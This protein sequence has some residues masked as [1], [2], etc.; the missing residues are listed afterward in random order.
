LF[1]FLEVPFFSIFP[2]LAYPM[3][4]AFASTFLCS[5]E[6]HGLASLV[7]AHLSRGERRTKIRV[8]QSSTRTERPQA[9]VI[10]A[11]T[12]GETEAQWKDKTRSI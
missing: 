9:E 5:Q 4:V 6:I 12:D 3:T 7:D 11:F 1:S 8:S 10:P 2:V